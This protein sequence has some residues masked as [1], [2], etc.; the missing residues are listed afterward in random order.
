MEQWKP[1]PG[2]EL[3]YEISD[4]GRMRRVADADAY[5]AGTFKT[6]TI[7]RDGYVRVR[8]SKDGKE[9]AFTV[10]S[11]VLSAF[12]GPRPAGHVVNHK[13]GK[14]ANNHV[15][16]LEYV[17]Q[18]QNLEHARVTG[19]ARP[20]RGIQT[21]NAKL[22]DSLVL[23]MV[24]E[25]ATTPIGMEHLATKYKVDV[26]CVVRI[27]ARQS[28]CHVEIPAD[29]LVAVEQKRRQNGRGTTH[30]SRR[31]T[32]DDVRTILVLAHDG[33]SI[34]AI[35]RRFRVSWQSISHILSGKN[36]KHVSQRWLDDGEAQSF[37]K[38]AA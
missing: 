34:A 32:E 38:Q 1:I 21:G 35:A 31:L 15:D 5:P 20:A 4:I 22:N 6:G 18:Q 3:L 28:W 25:Y 37:L 2:Y 16:N 19:L 17:T 30:H 13:D 9:R 24:M 36:W 11:L 26:S 12:V 10:H 7:G 27:L 29:V 33:V 23:A 8:L 14:K